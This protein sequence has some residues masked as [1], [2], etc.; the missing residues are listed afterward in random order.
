MSK[1]IINLC[2]VI[3]RGP[4]PSGLYRLTRSKPGAFLVSITFLLVSPLGTML[5]PPLICLLHYLGAVSH[6]L[7]RWLFDMC[8]GGWMALVAVSECVCVCVWLIV[9]VHEC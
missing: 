1:P 4:S 7:M 5:I 3:Q 6:A 9:D 2:E 8:V